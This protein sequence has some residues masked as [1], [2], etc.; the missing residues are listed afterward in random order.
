MHNKNVIAPI[1]KVTFNQSEARV[2]TAANLDTHEDLIN[3]V[4]PAIIPNFNNEPTI[5][6]MAH[7]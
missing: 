1:S 5:V 4:S 2:D 6:H 3:N 7:G